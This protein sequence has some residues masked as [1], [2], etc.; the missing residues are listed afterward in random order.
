MTSESDKRTRRIIDNLIK[1]ISDGNYYESHQA[2]RTVVTRYIKQKKINAAID[3]SFSGAKELSKYEQWGSV[4]DLL[5]YMLKI[6]K[7][8]E[9]KVDDESKDDAPISIHF[10]IL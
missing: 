2:I 3:L 9:I 1:N 7:D 8:Q 5:L 4:S 10:S 6:Y